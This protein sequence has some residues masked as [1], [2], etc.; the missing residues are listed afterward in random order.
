MC[1]FNLFLQLPTIIADNAGYDSSELI[2]QMR[3][4]HA[5]GKDCTGLSRRVGV[6]ILVNFLAVYSSKLPISKIFG[7][8]ESFTDLQ[9]KVW[10]PV[11]ELYTC[12]GGSNQGGWH[13]LWH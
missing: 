1:V 3:A 7:D 13:S 6:G 10:L 11:M 5:E 4:M 9:R 12:V 2:A 8:L